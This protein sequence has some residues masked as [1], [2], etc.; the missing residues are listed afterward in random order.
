MSSILPPKRVDPLPILIPA[1]HFP[2]DP[3]ALEDAVCEQVKAA[4]VRGRQVMPE[5][6][7]PKL[8]FDL[9]GASA[10]QAHP[11]R[12]GLRFNPVLLVANQT[13][14]LTEV[15]PHEMAHW[16]VFHLDGSAGMKPHGKEW[17]TMMREVFGLPPRVT[18]RFD[19]RHAQPRP[20]P[21]GCAC[22]THWLTPQRHA[23]ARKGCGYLCRQCGQKLIHQYERTKD[24]S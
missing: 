8:W 22:T 20:H 6:S 5:L 24:Q 15:V 19:I 4:L 3:P 9:S 12:G 7:T 10:G 16:M 11:G 1:E 23:R 2:L 21:Y 13:A 17:Q 18:H 14:F